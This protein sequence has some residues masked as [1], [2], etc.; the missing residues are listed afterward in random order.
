MSGPRCGGLGH[1]EGTVGL[2]FAAKAFNLVGIHLFPG[3]NSEA[4]A[5]FRFDPL[6]LR[7]GSL[8]HPPIEPQYVV[9]VVGAHDRGGVP[10]LKFTEL[11]LKSRNLAAQLILGQV[12][13]GPFAGPGRVRGVLP[14]E[15]DR[16][17][18]V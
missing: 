6:E 13:P 12:A 5:D 10:D 18:V 15:S 2:R 7:G 17:S 16:K 9:P 4:A 1:F 11:R 3:A 8:S 14:N